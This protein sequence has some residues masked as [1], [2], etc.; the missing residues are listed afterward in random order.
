MPNSVTSGLEQGYFRYLVKPYDLVDLT[1][2]IDAAIDV[3]RGG[4]AT[5]RVADR[6]AVPGFEPPPQE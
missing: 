1:D 3:S 6:D 2:A 5:R 4:D